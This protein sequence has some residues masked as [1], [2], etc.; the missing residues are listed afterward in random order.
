MAP[1]LVTGPCGCGEYREIYTV[2]GLPAGQWQRETDMSSRPA[3]RWKD[4]FR[5]RQ[6]VSEI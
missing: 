6:A 4:A 1:W 5:Y 3:D 2:H